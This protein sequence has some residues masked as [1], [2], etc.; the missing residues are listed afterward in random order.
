MGMKPQE[1]RENLKGVM[2]LVLAPFNEKN[3]LD[4][5]ALRTQLR[6]S[7]SQ[8]KGE[9][10]VFMAGASTSEFYAMSDEEN[11][12][13]NQIVIEE[14]SGKFPVILGTGR[15]GTSYTLETSLL[16]QEMGA[17]GVM[18]INPFYMP[19]TADGLYR[20]YKVLG[21]ELDIGII[22]YNNPVIASMWI[23]PPLMA[24]I[25]KIPNVVGDKDNTAS[26]KALYRMY[27]TIDPRD[28]SVFTGGNCDMYRYAAMFGCPGYVT[29]FSSFI[30]QLTVE[31]YKAGKKRDFETLNALLEKTDPLVKFIGTC[32]SRRSAIPTTTSPLVV[33]AEMTCFQSVCKVAM[34]LIGLPGGK[35]REPMENLTDAERE[36]LKQILIEIGI[37]V[38]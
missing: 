27:K 29:E 9:E 7:V 35:V 4:E 3:E 18:I 6:Y 23:A 24:K 28:M 32:A 31:I 22:I 15:A 1:L 36:E 10:V 8:F 12:R 13:Y 38:K 33:S 11:K 21:D 25:S 5:A 30:P 34:D 26:I 17:D 2:H 14:V 37:T 19:S 16:A 20:H